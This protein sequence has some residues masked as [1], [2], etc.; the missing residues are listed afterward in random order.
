MAYFIGK[1]K[2]YAYEVLSTKKFKRP[3]SLKRYG[4]NFAPQGFVYKD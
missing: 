1:K 2:G 4:V 3:L